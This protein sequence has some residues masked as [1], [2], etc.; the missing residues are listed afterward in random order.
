[1]CINVGSIEWHQKTYHEISWD[2][3]FKGT[4]SPKNALLCTVGWVDI[5]G[6]KI[7]WICV[8]L[9]SIHFYVNVSKT[10]GKI[11]E[12]TV[13]VDVTILTQLKR[14]KGTYCRKVTRIRTTVLLLFCS[15][16]LG[17]W[18][19]AYFE[20]TN[21]IYFKM[22]KHVN[23]LHIGYYNYFRKIFV[24]A[25]WGRLMKPWRNIILKTKL[26]AKLPVF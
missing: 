13:G 17:Y 5:L 21:D 14:K 7:F 3:P 20:N 11:F 2:Y 9:A 19:S 22:L 10:G 25:R 12:A 16:F 6:G 24:W 15:I 23:L 26:S 1:M 18:A 8:P 4:F